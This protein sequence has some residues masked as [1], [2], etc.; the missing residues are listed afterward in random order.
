MG[1]SIIY[2][3]VPFEYPNLEVPA[4]TSLDYIEIDRVQRMEVFNSRFI[5]K[6]EPTA[7]LKKEILNYVDSS[8]I[9]IKYN[10]SKNG[11]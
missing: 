8:S 5:L 4:Y 7:N 10:N 1:A 9:F 2:E 6:K 11:R 3:D